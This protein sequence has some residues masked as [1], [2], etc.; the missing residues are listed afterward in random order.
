MTS[1][2]WLAEITARA[3]TYDDCPREQAL[4]YACED[5]CEREMPSRP[6]TRDVLDEVVSRLAHAEDIDPP[7]VVVSGRLRRTAGAADTENRVIHLAGP[8]VALLTLVHELA[9][10]TAAVDGH[11]ADFLHEMVHLVRSHIGIEHA[12]FLHGL[13][14]TAGLAV[15]PWPATGR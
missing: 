7:R 13:Y 14:A 11:G 10:F 12:A 3:A 5:I 4:V 6:L 15:P 9:H 1:R 2:D 8:V